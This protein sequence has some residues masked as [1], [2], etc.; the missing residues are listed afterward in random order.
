M[1]SVE[2]GPHGDLFP[3]SNVVHGKGFLEFRQHTTGS[4]FCHRIPELRRRSGHGALAYTAPSRGAGIHVHVIPTWHAQP[5]WKAR[6]QAILVHTHQ[7]AGAA[8]LASVPGLRGST[9]V[10][11]CNGEFLEHAATFRSLGCRIIWVNCMTWI[12][13][14]EIAHYEKFGPFD[15]YVFQSEYQRQELFPKLAAYGVAEDRCRLIRGAFAFDEFPFR[16]LRHCPR[17]PFVFGRIARPDLDKWSSNL[18]PIYRAVQYAKKQAKVMAWGP[19]LTQKC[20][21]PPE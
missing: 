14:K 16:P 17:E 1:F 13:P 11:F 19:R 3:F 7:V 20:G 4:G 6:L 5:D 9:V 8:N 18:W 12:F 15:G 10:S 2:C 21:P